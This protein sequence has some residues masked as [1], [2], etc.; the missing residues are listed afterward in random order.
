MKVEG[1]FPRTRE[2]VE[3]LRQLLVIDEDTNYVSPA[4]GINPTYD[5]LKKQ[6]DFL[7]NELDSHL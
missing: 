3:E 2:I 7:R 1:I 6:I 5:R 4:P